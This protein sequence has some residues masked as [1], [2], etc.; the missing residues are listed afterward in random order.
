MDEKRLSFLKATLEV[1]FKDR[2]DIP[3]LH[4]TVS[5]LKWLIKTIE[6]QHEELVLWRNEGMI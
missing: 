4:F 1:D 2:H 3:Q 6:E 5:E